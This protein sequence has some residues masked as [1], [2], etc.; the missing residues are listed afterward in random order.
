MSKKKKNKNKGGAKA[1][2]ILK[3]LDTK[4]DAKN[5]LIESLK[6]LVIGVVGGGLAG[7]AIGKPSLAVGFGCTLAGNYLKSP[8]ITNLGFGMMASGGYQIAN[9]NGAPV[10]GLDGAKERIKVFGQNIK[11]RLYLD[12]I[13][14]QK[15]GES[16]N[17]IGEVQYFNYP[18]NGISMGSLEAI[19]QEI[20]N[21][22]ERFAARQM[23]GEDDI[24]GVEDRI[25]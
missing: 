2:A 22:S 19:E 6:T 14:K 1:L 5:S 20:A 8:L 18:Q 17:G 4:S 3:P 13:I 16:T 11:E 21:S 12:K 7:A 24:T 25:L 10:S 9:L 23:A 15:S